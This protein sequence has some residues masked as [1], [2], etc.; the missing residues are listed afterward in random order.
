MAEGTIRNVCPKSKR[1][2]PQVADKAILKA[3]IPTFKNNIINPAS[4][5]F[6]FF[7]SFFF[8]L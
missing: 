5:F 6:F 2:L 4:S 3:D 7:F 1:T 8:N